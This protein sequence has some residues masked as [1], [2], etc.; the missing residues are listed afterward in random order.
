MTIW[1]YL[2]LHITTTPNNNSQTDDSS[3]CSGFWPP[4]SSSIVSMNDENSSELLH[5]LVDAAALGATIIQMYKG[6]LHP[7]WRSPSGSTFSVAADMLWR[8][9]CFTFWSMRH[10]HGWNP[11]VQKR[12]ITSYL[13]IAIEK[14]FLC[15][16]GLIID[17]TQT[18]G[19]GVT[20]ADNVEAVNTGD[21]VATGIRHIHQALDI[22]TSSLLHALWNEGARCAN[23][24][25]HLLVSASQVSSGPVQWGLAAK[26]SCLCI[27]SL[28]SPGQLP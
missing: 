18:E 9:T 13:E 25:K 2:Y 26:R 21:G 6:S 20:R 4:G 12:T 7:T 17:M 5:L 24:G 22:F 23:S 15:C 28:W 1:C 11:H 14:Y 8:D 16:C 3:Q 19:G 27:V 10:L